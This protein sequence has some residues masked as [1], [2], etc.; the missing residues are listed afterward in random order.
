M[1]KGSFMASRN[2]KD[3]E[4]KVVFGPELRKITKYIILNSVDMKINVCLV[5][6]NF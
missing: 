3:L 1:I 5:V 6:Y 4:F 2:Y